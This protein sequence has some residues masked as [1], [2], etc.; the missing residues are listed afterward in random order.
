MLI[1]GLRMTSVVTDHR[2]GDGDAVVVQTCLDALS[3]GPDAPA[4]ALMALGIYG[5]TEHTELV[6]RILANSSPNSDTAKGCVI[7]LGLLKDQSR[8]AVDLLR[9]QMKVLDHPFLVLVA[10]SRIGTDD[11]RIAGLD[12]LESHYQVELA[13]DLMDSPVTREKAVELTRRYLSSA[14][15]FYWGQAI[16]NLVQ[17]VDD[18]RLLL[19]LVEESRLIEHLH[20]L[21]FAKEGGVWFVG[22]KARAILGLARFDPK[23]AFLAALKA[24]SNPSSNDRE[25]YPYIL[26]K[27]DVARAIP[28]LLSLVAEE[29]ST[30]VVWAIGRAL[31]VLDDFNV[32]LSWLSNADSLKRLAACRT[33]ERLRPETLVL[34]ALQP[35]LDDVDLRVAGAAREAIRRLQLSLE[36]ERLIEALL[37]EQDISKRWVLLD[38]LLAIGDPG[39]KQ[40]PMPDWARRVMEALPHFMRVYLAEELNRRREETVKE[41]KDRA[42]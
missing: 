3:A 2:V 21:A 8:E 36:A 28:A 23:A 37:V 26:V 27:L 4:G 24:L 31:A 32:I 35:C 30:A 22:S 11:V 39:D 40:R 34:Q 33:C 16:D 1:W 12:R 20:G 10:L 15:P 6:R 13:A 7:A 5:S 41:A 9:Q 18:N 14:E 17:Y 42:K 38:S 25:Y 19:S 29:K